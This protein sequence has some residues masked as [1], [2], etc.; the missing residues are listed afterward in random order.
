MVRLRLE[1]YFLLCECI[2]LLFLQRV[3]AIELLLQFEGGSPIVE[4]PL[5]CFILFYL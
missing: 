2:E 4:L 5:R 1:N 3:E